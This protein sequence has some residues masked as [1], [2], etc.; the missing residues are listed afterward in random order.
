MNLW[1]VAIAGDAEVKSRNAAANALRHWLDSKREVAG[2]FLGE[3][4]R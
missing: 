1:Y 2:Q 4:R 3:L